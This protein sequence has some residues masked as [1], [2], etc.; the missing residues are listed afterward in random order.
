FRGDARVHA[1]LRHGIEDHQQIHRYRLPTPPGLAAVFSGFGTPHWT[2]PCLA[3]PRRFRAG[4]QDMHPK[5]RPATAWCLSPTIAPTAIQS[6]MR[7]AAPAPATS[8]GLR[9]T[10]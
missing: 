7:S 9:R 5:S 4:R 2:G 8:T 1:L 6:F 3:A 10:V